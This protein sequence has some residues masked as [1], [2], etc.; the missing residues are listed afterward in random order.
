MGSGREDIDVRMLGSG[1]P[2]LLQA[3]VRHVHTYIH[4]NGQRGGNRSHIIRHTMASSRTRHA[5]T[6]AQVND[7]R[8]VPSTRE[9]VAALEGAINAPT[10][11]NAGG[12]VV[13]TRLRLSDK[14]MVKA[15]HE[16]AEAKQKLY[17]CLVW[18]GKRLSAD[19]LR[20]KLEALTEVEVLQKTPIRVLHRRSLMTR[21]KTV[22]ELRCDSLRPAPPTHQNEGEGEEGSGGASYFR[23]HM[24]TSAG[25]YVKE[26]V[27]GDLGRTV[28]SVGTLLGCAADILELDVT[29]VLL[30]DPQED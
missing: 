3:R 28:P 2:F 30:P 20:T 1:R 24:R 23:L 13:V 18:A 19:E 7:P 4:K 12:D 21:A 15:M 10:G 14:A 29:D 6:L 5:R 22:H 25:T 8:R 26:F 27:H 17:S 11:L 9:Q 16:G